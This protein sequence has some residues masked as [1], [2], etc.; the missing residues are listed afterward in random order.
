MA[1]VSAGL[2]PGGLTVRTL[3]VPDEQQ[4]DSMSVADLR[5]FIR[6]VMILKIRGGPVIRR[7]FLLLALLAMGTVTVGASTVG[8]TFTGGSNTTT[9]VNATR[10]WAF[11]LNQNIFVTALGLWDINVADPLGE[12]HEVGLWTSGGSLL[13]SIVVS[14]NAPLTGEFR[15][16][17]L[18]A[19]V[20]L[21]AGNTY[22]IGAVYNSVADTYRTGVSST[23]ILTAPQITY[24]SGRDAIGTNGS[25][26][27]P[28]LNSGT[29]RVFGPNILF[30]TS[31]VP[32]PSTWLFLG[33]GLAVIALR[34]C[35]RRFRGRRRK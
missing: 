30:E 20:A 33:S 28:S 17:A 18:P 8:L 14:P 13:A 9:A 35:T 12:S 22:V 15:F 3:H 2:L 4:P 11:L 16:N 10:G 23:N 21:V 5:A 1:A 29:G 32:E 34:L 26:T 25:L 19:S 27:F 24:V 31:E 7:A 6:F